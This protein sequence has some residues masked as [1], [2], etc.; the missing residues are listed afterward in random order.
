LFVYK[1]EKYIAVVA[2]K[3]IQ[4]GRELLADYGEEYWDI[5][6]AKQQEKSPSW[7]KIKKT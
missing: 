1:R 7:D 3:D 4:G 5:V 6:N 2:L